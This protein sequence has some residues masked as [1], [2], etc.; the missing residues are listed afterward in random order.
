MSKVSNLMADDPRNNPHYFWLDPEGL[1]WHGLEA[2]A[3]DCIKERLQFAT[4]LIAETESVTFLNWC[5]EG[6]NS[7]LISADLKEWAAE[8]QPSHGISFLTWNQFRIWSRAG[9]LNLKVW[10]RG[11][12]CMNVNE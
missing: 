12:E 6:A 4:R 11:R 3:T 8:V 9:K 7:Y 10:G 1:I 2:P 5:E